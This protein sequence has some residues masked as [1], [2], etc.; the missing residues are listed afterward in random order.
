MA[1]DNGSAQAQGMGHELKQ[2]LF[3]RDL[4]ERGVPFYSL[5]VEK[6]IH[7]RLAVVAWSSRALTVF[8]DLAQAS[9]APRSSARALSWSPLLLLGSIALGDDEVSSHGDLLHALGFRLCGSKFDEH[10]LLFIGLLVL[11]RR[12]YGVLSF[13]SLNRN[14]TRLR[15]KD[16]ERERKSSSLRYGNR[17]PDR[18]SYLIHGYESGSDL[19]WHWHEQQA[20]LAG[21]G[22]QLGRAGWRSARPS[23][24]GS[25]LKSGFSPCLE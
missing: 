2:G 18:V 25:G 5:S 10:E 6:M 17:T 7:R 22:Q 1:T 12:G 13:L 8:H 4:E 11:A 19:G 14:Q 24:A 15:W 20:A 9:L 23:W 3:L 16:L 21:V